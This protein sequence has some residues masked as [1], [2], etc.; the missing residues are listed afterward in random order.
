MPEHE[1]FSIHEYTFDDHDIDWYKDAYP[2]MNMQALEMYYKI[3]STTIATKMIDD[4]TAE[5]DNIE[6]LL[7]HSMFGGGRAPAVGIALNEK[8]NL[9]L[10]GEKLKKKFSQYNGFVYR[11]MMER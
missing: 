1:L 3:F 9:G 6:T 7:I 5:K 10:E 8:F 4:F 11:L 2:D